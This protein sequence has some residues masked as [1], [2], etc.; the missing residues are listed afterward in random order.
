MLHW[1]ATAECLCSYLSHKLALIS[2][3][4]HGYFHLFSFENYCV[5]FTSHFISP[6]QVKGF[7]ATTQHLKGEHP[8]CKPIAQLIKPKA[9]WLQGNTWH[10]ES[11]F[12]LSLRHQSSGA[13]VCV[14]VCVWGLHLQIMWNTPECSIW[15]TYLWAMGLFRRLCS[16]T[17]LRAAWRERVAAPEVTQPMKRLVAAAKVDP[18]VWPW[19]LCSRSLLACCPGQCSI[20]PTIEGFERSEQRKRWL[21][22]KRGVEGRSSQGKWG[23]TWTDLSWSSQTRCFKIAKLQVWLWQN[24]D[25][26]T[27]GRRCWLSAA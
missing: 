12:T 6:F 20:R 22:V 15:V 4:H 14:C 8:L 19:C 2:T 7:R 1:E 11:M 25:V 24:D 10:P 9:V 17:G 27:F 3:R 16:A 26:I 21:L 23:S 5:H 13:L 18:S